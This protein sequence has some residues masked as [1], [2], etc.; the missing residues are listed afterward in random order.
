MNNANLAR[1]INSDEVQ[2][3]LNP[4]KIAAKKALCKKNATKNIKALEMLDPYA[5]AARKAETRAMETRDGKKT[6]A[7][8]ARRQARK[9]FAQG[10]KDFFGK[11]SVQGDV[12]ENGFELD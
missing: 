12:C 3:V 2:S 1:I 5:A 7:A 8:A 4:A 11:A 6:S 9:G 10:K